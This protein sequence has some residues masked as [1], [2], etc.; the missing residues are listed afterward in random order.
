MWTVN[1][2]GLTPSLPRARAVGRVR[3]PHDEG[4]PGHCRAAPLRG[5]SFIESSSVFVHHPR[6]KADRA[7]HVSGDSDCDRDGP[8]SLMRRIGGGG[9][10][11]RR[12]P[13]GVFKLLLSLGYH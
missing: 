1:P 3:M 6:E 8:G 2:A 4:R 10:F 11:V 7:A 13:G 5:A 12:W 9:S